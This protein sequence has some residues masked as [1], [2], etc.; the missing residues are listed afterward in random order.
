[1]SPPCAEIDNLLLEY[2]NVLRNALRD[3]RHEFHTESENLMSAL[4]AA[5]IN[6]KREVAAGDGTLQ[7]VG[8]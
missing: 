2:L 4:E 8:R 7:Q 6:V 3:F 1:M 5:M